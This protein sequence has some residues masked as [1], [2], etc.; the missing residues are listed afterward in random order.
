MGLRYIGSKAR[1]AAEII[2]ELGAP[3]TPE[4]VFVDAFCGTGSVAV[5]AA[6]AGW[7]VR[8]NDSLRSAAITAT[9]R[10]VS[11]DQARFSGLGGY[12][13]AVAALNG[14]GGTVGFIAREYSPLSVETAGVERKYFTVANA[15]RID[16]ARAQIAAW[17]GAG[18]LTELEHVLLLADLMVA[19]NHV[20]NTAGTYGCFLRDWTATA[21]RPLR[22]AP[23]QLAEQTL[24]LEVSVGDVLD[25]EYQPEDVA[26]FDPPYTK[27]Q[28]AA[29]YHILETVAA[30]DEP[31]VGGVTGLRPWKHLA[32]DFCYRSRA[33]TALDRLVEECGA[34]RILLSYSNQGHVS[35]ADLEAVL[36]EHGELTVHRLGAIGRY[37]PNRAAAA[38]SSDV[39]EYLFDLRKPVAHLEAAA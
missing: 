1:V 5:A 2:D 37:R 14:L 33:L 4:G 11:R 32:S 3:G 13:A 28:Y 22:M 34:G 29:Y 24:R 39:N 25:V 19:V 35:R 38:H 31:D 9:A 20:A 27:R 6:E 18:E 21:M 30:G 15:R 7:G 10:L 17:Y 36:A 8:L 26:Y 16:A 12:E 23:R